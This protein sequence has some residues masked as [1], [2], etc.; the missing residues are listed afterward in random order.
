MEHMCWMRTKARRSLLS[1]VGDAD[2][3]RKHTG[4]AM[5]SYRTL[6]SFKRR[7]HLV[8]VQGDVRCKRLMLSAWTKAFL[9]FRHT[10]ESSIP[11]GLRLDQVES[12]DCDRLFVFAHS[13]TPQR[14]AAN[15]RTE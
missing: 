2:E 5:A 4:F 8:H 9:I 10:G 14:S 11:R 13:E 15:I 3:K 7:Q 1:S 12:F 6:V